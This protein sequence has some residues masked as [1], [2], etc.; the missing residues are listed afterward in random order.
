MSWMKRLAQCLSL[1][2]VGF[3]WD[4]A[5]VINSCN[6]QGC[7]GCSNSKWPDESYKSVCLNHFKQVPMSECGQSKTVRRHKH[8]PQVSSISQRPASNFFLN[9][10]RS[11]DSG[12]NY[13]AI[14]NRA[15]IDN[16][17]TLCYLTYNLAL[18]PHP[19]KGTASLSRQERL[20][21]MWSATHSQPYLFLKG[22]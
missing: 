1:M 7:L 11:A 8:L 4:P 10:R 22:L 21:H 6:K 3:W 13:C 15:I 2:M 17:V 19:K 18:A 16:S 9:L 14:I 5:G 12:C 20:M